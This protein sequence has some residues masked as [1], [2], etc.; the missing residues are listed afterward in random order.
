MKFTDGGTD[1]RNTL[2]SVKCATLCLFKELNLDM[3][4]LARCSPG[5]S[6]INPAERVMSILNLGLQNVSLQRKPCDAEF[7]TQLK[8]CGSMADLRK[9]EKKKPDLKQKE[10]W[11]DSVEPVQ[12]FIRNRFLRLSLKDKPFLAMDPVSELEI[13]IF[14]R[15]LRELFAGLDLG[16]L[17]KANISKND[18]YNTW[19]ANHCRERHY[20]FQ[21]KKCNDVACCLPPTLSPEELHWLPDPVS[22]LTGDHFKPYSEIKNIDTDDADRPSLKIKAKVGEQDQQ[23]Q[24]KKTKTNTEKEK[25]F[26]ST[27]TDQEST[28][29]SGDDSV[30]IPVPDA[31]LCITQNARAIVSCVEC[32]KPRLIYSHHRLTESQMMTVVLATSEYDYTCGGPLL[33]PCNTMYKNV[34]CRTSIACGSP[35]EM[36]YYASNLGR[37]DICCFCVA[38]NCSDDNDLK[39]KYKTVLPACKIC[40]EKG[41]T[42]IVA[43]P[44]GSKK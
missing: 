25:I 28:M 23:K 13:D 37:I 9:L 30:D 39:K 31:H 14:K 16:K 26:D 44:Y 34:M 19:I 40:V 38:E 5:H 35:V 21:I 43:R 36:Q 24:K 3:I 2:E 1:Q 33:P 32:Q 41:E 15:H 22:D 10:V 11:L 18:S 20:I 8:R 29:D 12:S 42:I 27:V 17:N 6:Y 4:I 7:E